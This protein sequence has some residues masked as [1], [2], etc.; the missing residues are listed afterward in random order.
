MIDMR[1]DTFTLPTAEMLEAMVTSPLGDDGYG[2]DP[3]VNR[4]ERLTAERLGKET[5]CLMPSGTMA[6]L[7]SILTHCPQATR[8]LVG[9]KSDIFVYEHSDASVYGG[10][11]YQPVRTQADGRLALEDLEL[12]V[13]QMFQ[14]FLRAAD[15]HIFFDEV[16][17]RLD[18][19]VSKRP[20]FAK[21]VV[22]SGFEIEFAET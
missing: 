5:A 18:V 22:R 13:G 21:A 12:A 3:T 2:E 11:I 17:I 10:V 9:D 1:S 4:L 19:L 14:T 20:I 8:V 16:V 7:A 15:A 6:N